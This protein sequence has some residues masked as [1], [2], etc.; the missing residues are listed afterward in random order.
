M[1]LYYLQDSVGEDTPIAPFAKATPTNILAYTLKIYRNDK[2]R[3]V[4]HYDFV[5]ANGKHLCRTRTCT[6]SREHE[7]EYIRNKQGI[8]TKIVTTHTNGKQ[9]VS[10]LRRLIKREDTYT[11]GYLTCRY[12]PN[13][14][15]TKT[16]KFSK[17]DNTV[18]SEMIDL[19]ENEITQYWEK[20]D[21]A[22]RKAFQLY[23]RH[24]KDNPVNVFDYESTTYFYED[25]DDKDSHLSHAIGMI[26]LGSIV[27]S[28]RDV[29]S[30]YDEHGNWRTKHHYEMN[31]EFDSEEKLKNIEKREIA[32]TKD[33]LEKVNDAYEEAAFGLNLDEYIDNPDSWLDGV[34][35]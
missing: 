14:K 26:R 27:K 24:D 30:D 15:L 34:P 18:Y 23:I 28:T 3:Q 22:G 20:Y 4:N 31:H 19:K 13:A 10:S 7:S 17:D 35:F 29:F 33:E 16:F 1:V 8:L 11:D 12:Y 9:E 6:R 5:A 21:W 2:L 25:Y 32:Y